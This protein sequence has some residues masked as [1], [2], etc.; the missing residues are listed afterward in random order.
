MRNIIGA[1]EQE[2]RRYK[3]LGEK[4]FEQLS[5]EQLVHIPA[6]SGNSIAII[7]WHISGNLKS[8]FTDFLATDGE[9]TWR[10]RESEFDARS[11]AH[12]GL[13]TKWDE[14]WSVLFTAL[15][16]LSD[17]MLDRNVSI[18]GERLTVIQALERSLAHTSYHVGQ[19]VFLAKM[20]RADGWQSLTIP[21]DASRRT[22]AS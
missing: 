7:V 3:E 15:S 12:A 13:L 8:R 20:M 10:D 17:E 14:G 22:K 1:I 9:K 19:I 18:R 2:Y 5:G 21:R 16:E 4:S 6:D 11:V